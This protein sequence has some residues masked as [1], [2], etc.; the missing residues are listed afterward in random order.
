MLMKHDNSGILLWQKY[1]QLEG[2]TIAYG[3]CLNS[4][5]NILVTGTTRLGGGEGSPL[6]ALFLLEINPT[7]GQIVSKYV[8]DPLA[9]TPFTFGFDLIQH[10]NGD[11]YVVAL[12][13]N[14]ISV[15]RFDHHSFQKA[16][17]W[18]E[19]KPSYIIHSWAYSDCLAE[20]PA[21]YPESTMLVL[22][23]TRS[24]PALGTIMEVLDS[25]LIPVAEN[26]FS[27]SCSDASRYIPGHG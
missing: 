2:G 13:S 20:I 15:V 21:G 5:G 3:S 6:E 17:W 1:Y 23:Y 26:S 18:I 27:F 10:S 22:G 12:C 14:K 9:D 25:N 24:H 19:N 4:S 7:N 11:Y 16:D 8:E